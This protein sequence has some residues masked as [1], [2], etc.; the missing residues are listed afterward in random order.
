MRLAE[1]AG[2]GN[3]TRHCHPKLKYFDFL[4]S[5]AMEFTTRCYVNSQMPQAKTKHDRSRQ[6]E[7]DYFG[8]ITPRVVF[9]TACKSTEMSNEKLIHRRQSAQSWFSPTLTFTASLQ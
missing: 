7:G 3:D 1:N 2:K 5:S 9:T 8:T 6:R 4:P